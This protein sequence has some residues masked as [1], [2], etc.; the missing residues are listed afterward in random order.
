VPS[1]QTTPVRISGAQRGWSIALAYTTEE[2]QFFF[3]APGLDARFGQHAV[4]KNGF[5][6]LVGEDNDYF[7]DEDGVWFNHG[8]AT[9][10][11]IL[12]FG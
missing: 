2:D 1:R 5:M 8:L 11:L 12:I 7:V 9:G 3:E 4:Y 10:D 6:L